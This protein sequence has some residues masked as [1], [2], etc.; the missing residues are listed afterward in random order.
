[1]TF[2][3]IQACP[4]CMVLS[5]FHDLMSFKDHSRITLQR[6][7]ASLLWGPFSASE[8]WCQVRLLAFTSSVCVCEKTFFQTRPIQSEQVQICLRQ[9]GLK[10]NP[11]KYWIWTSSETSLFAPHSSWSFSLWAGGRRLLTTAPLRAESQLV[12]GQNVCE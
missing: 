1:M 8:D 12:G 7:S 2:C 10:W 3:D 9:K 11:K 5:H 6:L 4:T